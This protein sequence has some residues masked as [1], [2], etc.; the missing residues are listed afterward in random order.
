MAEIVKEDTEEY[1][2]LNKK[3]VNDCACGSGRNLL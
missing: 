1:S 3:S 2:V